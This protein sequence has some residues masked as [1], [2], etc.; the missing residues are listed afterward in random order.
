[1]H[2][3]I[4]RD[5][6]RVCPICGMALE[7]IAVSAIEETNP[8]L[9]DMTRRC[10]V[11]A[12]LALPVMLLSMGEMLPH[13]ML[14]PWLSGAARAELQFGLA[15]PVAT[16]GV[17]VRD[18]TALETLAQV[19]TLVGEKTGTI[20]EGKPRLASISAAKGWKRDEILRLAAS[21]ERASEHPL[22]AA[23]VKGA[24]ERKIAPAPVSEFNPRPEPTFAG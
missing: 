13:K 8:E 7:P 24:F 18:A 10:S 19:D 6:P 11:A 9:R 14:A 23:I 21:V 20:T 5:A 1:M 4:I 12:L 15:T 16:A 2:P 17:L 22:A 3:E